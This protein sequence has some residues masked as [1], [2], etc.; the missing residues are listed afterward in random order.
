[1][2]IFVSLCF[3]IPLNS[4]CAE[5]GFS[6]HITLKTKLRNRLRI[7][8]IDA[9]MRCK[10]MIE[11]YKTFDYEAALALHNTTPRVVKMQ[12]VFAALGVLANDGTD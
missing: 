9:L 2:L 1:M 6:L 11:D 3:V 8:A 10:S 12:G 4:A 5:R 7:Q